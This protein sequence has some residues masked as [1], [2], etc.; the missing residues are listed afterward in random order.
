MVGMF[1]DL[2]TQKAASATVCV[3]GPD[4]R[5]G[6]LC[7]HRANDSYESRVNIAPTL[8]NGVLVP[9]IILSTLCTVCWTYPSFV[10]RLA[11]AELGEHFDE[12]RIIK[13]VNPSL[14]WG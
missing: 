13:V 5:T 4:H 14:E 1:Y 11:Y 2:P 12:C 3:F 8:W 6:F 9:S 7:N 10:S